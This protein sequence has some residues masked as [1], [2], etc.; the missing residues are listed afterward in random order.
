MS[1]NDAHTYISIIQ[2]LTDVQY[3]KIYSD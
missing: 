1:V 2:Q 3:Y